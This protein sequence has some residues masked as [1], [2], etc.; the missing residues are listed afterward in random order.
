LPSFGW[1]FLWKNQRKE[2]DE[3]FWP[4]V[5]G[6]SHSQPPGA[7]SRSAYRRENRFDK[8]A[9]LTNWPFFCLSF[10]GKKKDSQPPFLAVRKEDQFVKED[11]FISRSMEPRGQVFQILLNSSSFEKRP[12]GGCIL[13]REDVFS[14]NGL[15]CQ[16]LGT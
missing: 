2:K 7:Q 13:A 11:E 4:P 15:L 10:A 3:F 6:W 8:E 12:A 5:G 9:I 16:V 1:A 14:P